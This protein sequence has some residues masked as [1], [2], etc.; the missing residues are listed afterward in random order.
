V[1]KYFKSKKDAQSDCVYPNLLNRDFDASLSNRKWVTD[2]SEITVEEDKFIFMLFMDL[3]NRE[4]IAFKMSD[5]PNAALVEAT[6]KQVMKM[7]KFP[8]L[9]NVIIHSDQGSQETTLFTEYV[10]QSKLL[11]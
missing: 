9:T 4:I 5:N 3:C 11:G 6:G 2:I 7:R 8:D 1:K 10:T